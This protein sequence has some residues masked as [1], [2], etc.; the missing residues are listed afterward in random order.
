MKE[1]VIHPL[2]S[3]RQQ[4]AVLSVQSSLSAVPRPSFSF[5]NLNVRPVKKEQ[6][7]SGIVKH[8]LVVLLS[9]FLCHDFVIMASILSPNLVLVFL[10]TWL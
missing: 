2:C 8:S 9:V 10:R 4:S 7:T 6:I 5:T 1:N 3:Q